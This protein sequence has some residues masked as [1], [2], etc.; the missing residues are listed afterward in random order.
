MPGPFKK[1]LDDDG[2]LLYLPRYC[3][4]SIADILKDVVWRND[5]ITMFGKTHPQPRMTA[6]HGTPGLIYT[7]SKI[8]MVSPGWTPLLLNIKNQLE[9]DLA[10][11]FNSVLINYYRTGLDHMSYHSDSE[12]EL[13]TNPTIASLSFGAKRKFQMK[14]KFQKDKNV[15]SV[16]LEDG[17]L[18]VMKDEIQHFWNHK[19]AKTALNVA[20]RLNLTF[21]NIIF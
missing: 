18:L 10:T 12:K 1:L 19:I 5:S 15:L 2:T 16:E 20:P 6:W 14:H 3:S 17:S 11:S 9:K 21:R 7:Y 4:Y 13:G 8:R